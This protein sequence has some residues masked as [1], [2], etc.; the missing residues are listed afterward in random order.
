MSVVQIHESSR[1]NN[2]LAVAVSALL[3]FRT[4]GGAVGMAI[5]TT[6]LHHYVK[7]HLSKSLP[8]EQIDVL[9][10]NPRAFAELS[11]S[12]IGT[13]KAVFAQGYNLQM[14]IMIGFAAAQIPVTFFMWQ[15]K[16]IVV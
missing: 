2:S 8:P 4:M 11:P 5:V 14:R 10:K 16:Q 9:L 6:A 3:Q 13:A 12:V 7:S 15:K 1:A